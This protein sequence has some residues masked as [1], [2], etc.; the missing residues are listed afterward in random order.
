MRDVFGTGLRGFLRRYSF[1]FILL[2]GAIGFILSTYFILEYT[3]VD[4]KAEV[5]ED[6]MPGVLFVSIFVAIVFMKFTTFIYNKF[7]G[8]KIT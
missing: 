2:S 5:L 7:L 8:M 1:R 4:A 3:L 6:S